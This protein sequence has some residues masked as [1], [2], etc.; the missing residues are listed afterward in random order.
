MIEPQENYGFIC[1]K[2]WRLVKFQL[3]KSPQKNLHPAYSVREKSLHLTRP[4][5]YLCHMS[6]LAKWL[7]GYLGN[8][9]TCQ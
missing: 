8:D 5:G 7:L 3:Q 1:D 4:C 2:S 9:I 6:V